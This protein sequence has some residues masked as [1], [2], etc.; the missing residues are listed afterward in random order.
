M[1]AMDLLSLLSPD[2]RQ[3]W[4]T[5]DFADRP[6]AERLLQRFAERAG[7]PPE[8]TALTE[9]L[10]EQLSDSPDPEMA[11]LNLERWSGQL[12]TPSTG[13]RPLRENPR[14]LA[15][16]LAI[17]SGSQYLSAILIREP[18]LHGMFEEAPK[19]RMPAHYEGT[20]KS[21]LA[22]SKRAEGR[23]DALRRVKR[24]ELLRI[25]WRDL[26][27]QAPFGELVREISDLTDALLLGALRLAR[28][29]VDARFATAARETRFTALALGKLGA[30]ESNFSGDVDL[31]VVM[32]TVEGVELGELHRRYA[33]RLAETFIAALAQET[34]EGRCARVDMRLRPE[35]RT[36]ALVRSFQA[37]CT[38]YE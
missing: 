18:W 1:V 12:P 8:A 30:R 21:A 25:G 14:L 34:A 23:R 37:F 13:L 17:L 26:A 38:Y 4:E 24:R 29:E 19:P 3:R 32:D 27:R 10:L 16:L 20:V 36:G 5:L 33:T 9:A 31:V 6:R 15:D 22:A 11:L 35:G 7:D 2:P 28:E